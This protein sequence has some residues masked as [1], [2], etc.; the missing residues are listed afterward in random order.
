M[1]EKNK[2][3]RA[4]SGSQI[5]FQPKITPEIRVQVKQKGEDPELEFM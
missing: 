3:L 2:S 1:F 5:Q 4:A